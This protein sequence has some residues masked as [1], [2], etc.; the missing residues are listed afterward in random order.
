MHIVPVITWQL[1]I[2]GP[3]LVILSKALTGTLKANT[4]ERRQA[5]ELAVK[6][7]EQRAKKV[8]EMHEVAEG[9]LRVV[10]ELP[11]PEEAA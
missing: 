1:E 10:S 6:L 7:A 9:T 5:H 3:E 8:R 2:T 4:G 11:P